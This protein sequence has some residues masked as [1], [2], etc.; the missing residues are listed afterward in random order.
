MVMGITFGRM[1]VNMK[2]IIDSI[3]STEKEPTPTQTA[4]SIKVNGRKVCNM[5]L[6]V[7]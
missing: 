6:V 4:A 5:E 2:G 3:R 7:L 1:V